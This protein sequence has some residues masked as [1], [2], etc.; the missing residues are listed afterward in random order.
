MPEKYIRVLSDVVDIF[1]LKLPD[2]IPP[3]FKVIDLLRQALNIQLSIKKEELEAWK[4]DI[5]ATS[6]Y[7]D[8]LK[9]DIKA[10]E[11]LLSSIDDCEISIKIS[12]SDTLA[13][14]QD[15]VLANL[16]FNEK[17]TTEGII[18]LCDVKITQA[19]IA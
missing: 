17:P 18:E 1:S 11:S 5:L 7:L 2:N 15:A 8:D 14:D 12:D 4:N 16:E 10:I 9:D 19:T 6:K 3:G 13:I